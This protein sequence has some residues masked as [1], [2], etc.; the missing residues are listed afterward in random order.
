MCIEDYDG[1]PLSDTTV[2]STTQP[3][4]AKALS[5]VTNATGFITFANVTAGKYQFNIQRD[6]FNDMNQ[7]INFSGQPIKITYALTSEATAMDVSNDSLTIP[8][9][10]VVVIIVVIVIGLALKRRSKSNDPFSPSSFKLSQ[11]K[12]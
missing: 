11:Y 8:V 6:G 4:G 2:S 10:V 1:N 5:G 3:V 7:T 9:T 12:R